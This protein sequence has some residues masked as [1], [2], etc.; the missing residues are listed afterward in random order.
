MYTHL[1]FH[2][3]NR[4]MP[5]HQLNYCSL[6][7]RGGLY[8]C[9][10]VF[11]LFFVSVVFVAGSH[12]LP[13]I[14]FRLG[15]LLPILF[16]CAFV[17]F[18]LWLLVAGRVFCAAQFRYIIFLFFIFCF[19]FF[20]YSFALIWSRCLETK[21]TTNI[22]IVVES[23]KHLCCNAY[24]LHARTQQEKTELHFGNRNIHLLK[25]FAHFLNSISFCCC[26]F[27]SP[28]FR[29]RWNASKYI[30]FRFR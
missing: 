9:A 17:L 8:G 10:P 13:W 1:N 27:T 21:S 28:S 24:L 3:V 19:F 18:L 2:T 30:L 20:F 6:H 16:F 23:R 11:F 26:G 25:N 29:C 5:M 15:L 12:S 22:T 7:L 14:Y 4:I